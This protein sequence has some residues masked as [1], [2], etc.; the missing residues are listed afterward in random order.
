M[1]AH[2]ETVDPIVEADTFLAFGRDAQAE[3]ILL[4]ALKTDPRR[5]A[6]HLKLLDI[7]AERKNVSQFESVARQLHDLTAGVGSDWE[8][9]AAMGADLDP[10]NSLYRSK[11]SAG[12]AVTAVSAVD[13]GATMIFQSVPELEGPASKLAEPVP[14]VTD[15]A[16]LDFDLGM[17]AAPAADTAGVSTPPAEPYSAELDFDLDLGASEQSASNQNASPAEAG[18]AVIP[19]DLDID[20]PAQEPAAPELD[21][22]LGAEKSFDVE[23]TQVGAGE[24]GGIDFDFDLGTE[25]NASRPLPQVSPEV[26]V[27]AATPA[28]P[29][30]PLNLG[31]ISLELD[32]PAAG[33]SDAPDAASGTD[34]PDNPEVATKIELAMAYEEMGDRDG[35][36][37]LLQEAVAEGSPAQQK[38]ARA[39]LDSLA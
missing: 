27:A 5:Q 1:V 14:T 25:S 21:L 33:T 23:K 39:K 11:P 26:S 24:S 6:I 18:S 16:P 36:R 35:A 9:A 20:M 22:P 37:E 17:D 4:E 34:A 8:K 30:T 10:G 29:M 7:Y 19:L 28:P 3:E 12:Q 32:T 13:M 31:D 38:A 15:A 2:Q